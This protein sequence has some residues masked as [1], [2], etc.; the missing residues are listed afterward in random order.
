MRY[1]SIAALFL[2]AGIFLFSCSSDKAQGAFVKVEHFKEMVELCKEHGLDAK[3]IRE[4]KKAPRFFFKNLPQDFAKTENEQLRNEMFI[5]AI[6][7]IIL[8]ANENIA[9]DREKLIKLSN[10]YSITSEEEEWLTALQKEYEAEHLSISELIERVDIVPV[11]LAIAQA[12]QESWWGTSRFAL[13]G[14]A[15]F[16]EHINNTSGMLPKEHSKK[17]T[18]S[19]KKFP[20][21][22]R[23]VR[24]YADKIN[25]VDAY[26]E[27]R[28]IRAAARKA[29]RPI[30]GFELA[31]GL[32]HYSEQGDKYI[33]YIQAVITKNNLEDLDRVRLVK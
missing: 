5:H 13:E 22:Y 6:G 18:W 8:L 31:Q 25:R 27:L 23:S 32:G 10:Q 3:V 12:A 4:T 16:G 7:P 30:L 21:I 17:I 19:V 9:K 1:F 26:K 24:S 28:D 33:T 11:S 15:F 20:S 29:G 2:V 14:N